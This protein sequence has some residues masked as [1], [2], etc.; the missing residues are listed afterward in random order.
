[1]EN[2]G[3]NLEGKYIKTNINFNINILPK[4][5]TKPKQPNLEEKSD[6]VHK[7]TNRSSTRQIKSTVEETAKFLV[8][9]TGGAV[10]LIQ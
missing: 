6:G 7:F 5:S 2:G 10:K 4:S 3:K 8:I 9:K 1:M